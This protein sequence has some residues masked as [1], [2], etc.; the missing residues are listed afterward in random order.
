MK[1]DGHR[2]ILVPKAVEL[3]SKLDPV[4]STHIYPTGLN[5]RSLEINRER[6][7]GWEIEK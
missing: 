2:H 5:P 6:N 7:P 1:I 3:A 4:R